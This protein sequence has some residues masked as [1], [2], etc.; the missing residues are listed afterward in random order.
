MLPAPQSILGEFYRGPA[1]NRSSRSARDGTVRR[2][3]AK[4]GARHWQLLAE[5]AGVR[6]YVG[7]EDGDAGAVEHADALVYL[8]FG[9]VEEERMEEGILRLRRAWI[10]RGHG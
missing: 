9:G 2:I 3:H 1:S 8:G 10:E 4:G 7:H 6:I 5:Q